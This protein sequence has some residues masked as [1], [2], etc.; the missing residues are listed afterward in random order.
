MSLLE[1]AVTSK[2]AGVLVAI[3]FT[4]LFNLCINISLLVEFLAY[5][6]AGEFSVT[7]IVT[8]PEPGNI[9]LIFPLSIVIFLL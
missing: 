5:P 8:Y 4:V 6:G 1:S 9:K 2:S 7:F 3:W